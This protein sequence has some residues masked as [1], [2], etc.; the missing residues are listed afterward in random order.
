MMREAEKA[1]RLSDLREEL[2]SARLS[3]SDRELQSSQEADR[4]A[5]AI[6]AELE[7]L[8][9]EEKAAFEAMKP[10]DKARGV[11]QSATTFA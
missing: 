8:V 1:Q 4:E 3:G 10:E 2:K 7:K 9:A 6:A 11:F 5:K